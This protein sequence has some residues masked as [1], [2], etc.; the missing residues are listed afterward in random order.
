MQDG[1]EDWYVEKELSEFTAVGA[2]SKYQSF[3]KLADTA[4]VTMFEK[5]VKFNKQG[6]VSKYI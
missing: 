4:P 5:L 6:E 1:I 2:I 3:T